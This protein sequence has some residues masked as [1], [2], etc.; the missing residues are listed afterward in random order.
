MILL[1]TEFMTP[2]K[3]FLM[4]SWSHSVVLSFTED[5]MIFILLR[6][7]PHLEEIDKNAMCEWHK[8]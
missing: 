2:V 3:T 6:Y 5:H 4:S 7:G 8:G 1:L